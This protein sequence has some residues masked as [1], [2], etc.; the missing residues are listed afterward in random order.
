MPQQPL[1]DLHDI[2]QRCGTGRKLTQECLD[3]GT[4]IIL[5]ETKISNVVADKVRVE[6]YILEDI[7]GMSFCW[8]TTI[9]QEDLFFLGCQ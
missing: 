4:K 2:N 6:K 5:K 3:F 1:T 7:S 8:T 9:R